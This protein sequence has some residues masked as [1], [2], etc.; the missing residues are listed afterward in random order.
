MMTTAYESQPQPSSD[1][2][3]SRDAS[4]RAVDMGSGSGEPDCQ[5]V[6]GAVTIALVQDASLPKAEIQTAEHVKLD[7]DSSGKCCSLQ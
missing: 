7:D 3:V 2:E 4:S 5:A 6:N 1:T